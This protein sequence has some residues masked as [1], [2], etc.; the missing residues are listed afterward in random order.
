MDSLVDVA[1]L[2]AHLN[3][4]RLVVLDCTVAF[5]VDEGGR[6]AFH[7]GRAAWEA[8]HIP[9]SNFADI[10]GDLSDQDSPWQFTLPDAEHFESAMEAI[11]VGD[12]SI[13]ILYDTTYSMWAT[14][15]WWMLNAF[16]FENAAVLDGGFTAWKAAG[17][18]IT[19]APPTVQDATFTAE[20]RDGWFADQ[21]DV[22]GAV[23]QP[24]STCVVDALMPDMY[25]GASM[26]Y[27][28]AG[29]IPGAINLPAVAV[30][31]PESRLFLNEAELRK[32]FNAALY[33]PEQSV[34]TYCGGGI[35]ATADAFLLKRLGKDNVAV[36]DGS[37]AQWAADPSLPL[38]TGENPR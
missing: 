26:P 1:W 4:P 37:M 33:D 2:Q 34:I 23:E 13:V 32:M 8:A 15:V 9:R 36:Y 35:A 30:V 3:E 27:G 6:L 29:H 19:D 21:G 5:E 18:E 10:L 14:R 7:S 20:L 28:R 38:V 16:G 24:A 22:L 31:D 17:G 11:G 12:G 25:S